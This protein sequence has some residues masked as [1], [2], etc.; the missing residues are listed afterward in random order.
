[1]NGILAIEASQRKTSVAV[2][3]LDG[4]VHERSATGDARERDLLLPAIVELC[5][6][7]GLTQRDLTAVAVSTGPGGF[8]G[9]RVALATA[10]GLCESLSIPAVDVAS[11]L[12]AAYGARALWQCDE[13]ASRV[14][15]ALGCKGDSCWLSTVEARG[16]E[17]PKLT[18]EGNA[19]AATISDPSAKILIADEFLPSTLRQ[20]AVELGM[21]VV[22]PSFEARDCLAVAE[23]QVAQ[24]LTMDATELRVRYPREP[25]AVTLWRARYPNGFV[26]KK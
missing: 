18:H 15:V 17:M 9:L 19:T 25:E 20:R 24:G 26:A 21:Q 3:G 22:E 8:T 14:L 7:A 12:V 16:L 11:A 4:R 10:K 13:S 23:S 6:A 5:R 1:M 2:R